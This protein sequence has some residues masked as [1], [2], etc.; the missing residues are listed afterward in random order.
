MLERVARSVM[1]LAMHVTVNVSASF[2]I[3]WKLRYFT[4]VFHVLS[5]AIKKMHQ[6]KNWARRINPNNWKLLHNAINSISICT[7]QTSLFANDAEKQNLKADRTMNTIRKQCDINYHMLGG[8]KKNDEVA[9]IHCVVIQ[10]SPLSRVSFS[11]QRQVSTTRW[12]TKFYYIE[13]CMIQ[14]SFEILLTGAGQQLTT[15]REC[16]IKSIQSSG[17]CCQWRHQ[18][19]RII[20]AWF[21]DVSWLNQQQPSRPARLHSWRWTI[22]ESRS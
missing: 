22:A 16:W 7:H 15:G 12:S 20:E 13:T 1:I 6:W 19:R 21:A 18:G 5:K 4:D 9:S 3:H 8:K 14:N 11:E 17:K 10:E 2:F